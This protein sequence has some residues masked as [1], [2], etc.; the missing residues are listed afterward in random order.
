MNSAILWARS[1]SKMTW[2]MMKKKEPTIPNPRAARK[3]ERERAR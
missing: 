3:R 1:T 2:I